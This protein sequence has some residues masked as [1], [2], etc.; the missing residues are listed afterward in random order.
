MGYI[1]HTYYG[2]YVIHTMGDICHTYYGSHMSALQYC[3]TYNLY[4]IVF[5][6]YLNYRLCIIVYYY[7]YTIVYD[8]YMIHG[9]HEYLHTHTYI[10][11]YIYI[12][13][14]SYIHIHIH[15][16]TNTYTYIIKTRIKQRLCIQ[17]PYNT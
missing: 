12:Y 7:N 11:I 17:I 16:H 10:Y 14:H 1:C 8:S 4:I 9:I 2:I 3:S 5:Q 6:L 15:T 13:T